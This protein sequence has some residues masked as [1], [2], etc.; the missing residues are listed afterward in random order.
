M[1]ISSQVHRLRLRAEWAVSRSYSCLIWGLVAM[2]TR[3]LSVTLAGY[4]GSP[5]GFVYT[6]LQKSHIRVKELTRLSP[7]KHNIA[8]TLLGMSQLIFH[9]D[10]PLFTI[11][12]GGSA[13]ASGTVDVCL[14]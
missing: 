5:H 7:H 8:G 9:L 6:Y 2:R 10:P 3:S 13:Y 12:C 14:S 11:F 1:A 4:Y